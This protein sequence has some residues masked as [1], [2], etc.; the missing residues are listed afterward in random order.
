MNHNT[1]IVYS[2]QT[3]HIHTHKR[4]KKKNIEKSKGRMW[5]KTLNDDEE[6]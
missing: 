1:K 6:E 4:K 5:E 2:R 3:T